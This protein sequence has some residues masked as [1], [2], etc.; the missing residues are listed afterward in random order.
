MKFL[1]KLGL[2]LFSIIIMVISIGILAI[3][4]D[5]LELQILIDGLKYIVS[6]DISTKIAIGVSIVLIIYT[7]KCIFFNSFTK[8]EQKNKDNILLENEHGKLLVSKDTIQNITNNVVKNFETAETVMT[9]VNFDEAN[10]LSVY[11]TLAVKP[12]TVIKELAAKLQEDVKK[13][14]KNSIDLEIKSVNIKVKNIITKK[15][16]N[17]K[18]SQEE[19]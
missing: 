14:I 17:I 8:D 3:A 11:I 4:T 1:D 5:W 9:K 2:I 12:E 6:N 16:N 7:I 13:A 15:E 18:Q 19:K 10:N